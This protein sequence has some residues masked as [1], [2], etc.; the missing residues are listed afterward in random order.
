MLRRLGSLLMLPLAV[1]ACGGGPLDSKSFQKEAETIQSFAAEGALLAGDV[2]RGR[3]L[4]PYVRVHAGELAKDAESVAEKLERAKATPAVRAKLP[5]AV[6]LA[7]RVEAALTRL[8]SAPSDR[9][10]A[11]RVASQLDEAAA[12][13]SELASS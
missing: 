5:K 1:A 6:R 12:S 11:R 9:D 7:R 10:G 8:E 3:S 13:A 2:A 4:S